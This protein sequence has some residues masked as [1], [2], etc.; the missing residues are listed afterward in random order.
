MIGKL[1]ERID[2][3]AVAFDRNTVGDKVPG[4]MVEASVWAE[5]VETQTADVV[6]G[7]QTRNVTTTK[8]RIRRRPGLS[9]I[10][11]LRWKSQAYNVV[12]ILDAGSH[13]D[14][15]TLVAKCSSSG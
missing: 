14:T 1:R 10:K 8:F 2:L 12:G 9:G 11:K 7:N 15:L 6:Q 5:I 4:E 13:D 3:I